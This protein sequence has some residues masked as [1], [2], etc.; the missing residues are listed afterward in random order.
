MQYFYN[1][2][3]AISLVY[4][5]GIAFDLHREVFLF[6]GIVLFTALWSLTLHCRIQGAQD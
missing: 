3:S 6:W 1:R 2:S 4:R 5:T